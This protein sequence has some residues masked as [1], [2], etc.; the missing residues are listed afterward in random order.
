MILLGYMMHK[1]TDEV[2]ER[3]KEPILG[4]EVPFFVRLASVKLMND[5]L[6]KSDDEI[7]EEV[8]SQGRPR[9]VGRTSPDYS[10]GGMS[11]VRG[12]LFV[13]RELKRVIDAYENLTKDKR[14]NRQV[15]SI[16]LQLMYFELPA[17]SKLIDEHVVVA[18]NKALED[19]TE[20]MS[21]R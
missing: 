7:T 13:E 14:W 12:S 20:I 1:M 4:L 6:M 9:S 16:I 11:T 8:T 17:D 3:F 10:V 5:H 18:L 19:R 15:I 21:S 2:N